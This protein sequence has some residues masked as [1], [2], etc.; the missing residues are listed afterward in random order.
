[1]AA[2]SVE[3]AQVKKDV[4]TMMNSCVKRDD[5]DD[6]FFIDEDKK[7]HLAWNEYN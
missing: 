7:V 2:I 6:S 4:S 3:F 5:L 1:M